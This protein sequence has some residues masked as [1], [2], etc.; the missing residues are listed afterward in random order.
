MDVESFLYVLDLT[1]RDAATRTQL[2]T[3][4]KCIRAGFSRRFLACALS[5]A[6]WTM[7]GIGACECEVGV[8][9]HYSVG[10]IACTQ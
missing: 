3:V 6:G 2:R 10:R 4:T 9:P 5:S 8:D 1:E 7:S